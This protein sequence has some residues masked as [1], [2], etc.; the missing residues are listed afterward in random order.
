M[1]HYQKTAKKI[2]LGFLLVALV[3]TM[4]PSL[5]QAQ[6]E[7]S[8]KVRN[9]QPD[10]IYKS[11]SNYFV[12]L[13]FDLSRHEILSPSVYFSWYKSGSDIIPATWD[14]LAQYSCGSNVLMRPGSRLIKSR[15]EQK[16]Y[17][18]E[19][20]GVLRLIPNNEIFNTLGYRAEMITVT[21]PSLLANYTIGEP[22]TDA[23]HPTGALVKHRSS[24]EVYYIDNG[25]KRY[26]TQEGFRLNNFQ[27]KYV[28]ETENVD[29]YPLGVPIESYEAELAIAAGYELPDIIAPQVYYQDGPNGSKE[30][31]GIV[32]NDSPFGFSDSFTIRLTKRHERPDG[33]YQNSYEYIVDEDGMGPLETAEY[34]I[35][36]LYNNDP[37]GNYVFSISADFYNDIK[38]DVEGNNGMFS[39]LW[40]EPVSTGQLSHNL[41]PTTPVGTVY[42]D[43]DVPVIDFYLSASQEDIRSPIP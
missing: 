18:V 40:H 41:S 42:A 31:R 33:T 21:A 9:L 7:N 13:G 34:I 10:H 37:T 2:G 5:A 20:G 32:K 24:R 16:I 6:P 8:D 29:S 28:I 38:E 12:Y 14:E 27:S 43:V 3:L 35:G 17:A 23:M 39:E 26:I 1:Q 36:Y 4:A 19:P 25:R 30:F 22:L 15:E 11:G